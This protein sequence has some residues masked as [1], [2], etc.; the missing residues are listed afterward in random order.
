[1]STKPHPDPQQL[2]LVETALQVIARRGPLGL[3]FQE[4]AQEAGVG[5]ETL[6]QLFGDE[7]Q[8]LIEALY[9]SGRHSLER[10]QQPH[11]PQDSATMDALRNILNSPQ[12]Q[13]QDYVWV[14]FW[15]NAVGAEA[16]KAPLAEVNQWHREAWRSLL[17]RD[18][19][20]GMLRRD[21][22]LD[23]ETERLMLLIDGLALRSAL[24]VQDWPP[25]RQLELLTE[26]LGLLQ[27]PL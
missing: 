15:G 5:L 6:T 1:M 26:S 14:M 3:T 12:N 13:S 7:Q 4:V 10:M 16:M 9:L 2:P 25:Q 24:E 18:S 8:L 20:R 23:L 17:E 21:L 22:D 19:K 27:D 11:D